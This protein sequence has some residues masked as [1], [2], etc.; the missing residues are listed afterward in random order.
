MR[1]H[2]NKLGVWLVVALLL[3][4]VSCGGKG[5]PAISTTAPP[6]T[7]SQSEATTSSKA[8]VDVAGA[9][10]KLDALASPPGVEAARFAALKSALRSALASR[11]CG[12]I[13]AA[14]ATGAANRPW[15]IEAGL[16]DEGDFQLRWR[17][18]NLGDYSNDGVVG[19]A[20][21][22]P[23]A[24]HFGATP[25][26]DDEGLPVALGDNEYLAYVDGDGDGVVGVGDITPLASHFGAVLAGYRVYLGLQAEGESAISWSESW[27]TPPGSPDSLWTVP[28]NPS[29]ESGEL[30]RY[31][32]VAPKVDD[33]KGA[34]YFRVVATDGVHEGAADALADPLNVD[35]TP[36]AEPPSPVVEPPLLTAIPGDGSVA[37]NWSA[38]ADTKTPPV[39][40]TL[41]W[42]DHPIVRTTEAQGVQEAGSVT[43]AV[44][45]GLQ[46]ARP[47]WFLVQAQDSMSP[48]NSAAPLGPVVATPNPVGIYELPPSGLYELPGGIGTST[49]MQNHPSPGSGLNNPLYEDG[50][51]AMVW[52]SCTEVK[53]T[54]LTYGY[55][56][57]GRWVTYE[58]N[59]SARCRRPGFL[60]FGDHPYV[61]AANLDEPSLDL[62]VGDPAGS[63][64]ER[65]VV[66]ATSDEI[67]RVA[68]GVGSLPDVS[69]PVL[70]VAYT[71]AS[72]S[73][74]ELNV[75]WRQ[76]DRIGDWHLQRAVASDS[77]MLDVVAP[78]TVEGED[79]LSVL[80]THGE[81]DLDHLHLA[82]LLSGAYLAT[83]SGPWEVNPIA[84]PDLLPGDENPVFLHT[85][86]EPPFGAGIPFAMSQVRE[87]TIFDQT[88]VVGSDIISAELRW[89]AGVGELTGAEVVFEGTTDLSDYADGEIGV[90]WAVFPSLAAEDDIVLAR[91]QGTVL[92][93]S[94]PEFRITS[95]LVDASIWRY[96]NGTLSELSIPG[97]R[98]LNAFASQLFYVKQ[99]NADLTSL[100][101]PTG[102][103]LYYR[104]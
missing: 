97:G 52:V 48:P 51:P 33:F 87:T 25:L 79:G 32:F 35:T 37:L 40:Y 27:L 88:V 7:D 31:S 76:L 67:L 93:A 58:I 1:H 6:G 43:E 3:A 44:V 2:L 94:D 77:W 82:T 68:V 56:S 41:Y 21:V 62:Y 99:V 73:S 60:L 65:E 18:A 84:V 17:G 101:V 49:R 28:F 100:D 4:L 63:A 16:T 36:D 22:T 104:E 34:V 80:F 102:P 66:D 92:F 26:Y 9:L 75:A 64:W 83:A 96:V 24:A 15:A 47:L 42:A 45:S 91:G 81:V 89:N 98:E 12:R 61:A 71:T 11:G 78:V 54:I 29:R 70:V 69:A 5:K 8:K 103:L 59:P 23:L 90:D 20:D 95:G 30:Q 53:N 19:I 74:H 50:A 39:I 86:A 57:K 38:W 72:G 14:A 13:V 85:R 10:A 46:N 55:F